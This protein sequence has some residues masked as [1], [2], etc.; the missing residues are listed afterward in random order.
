MMSVLWWLMVIFAILL[1]AYLFI[2]F[3]DVYL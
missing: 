2:V 3:K 1:A